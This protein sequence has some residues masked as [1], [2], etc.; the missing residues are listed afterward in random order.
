ME[1]LQ[2]RFTFTTTDNNFYYVPPEEWNPLNISKQN[3]RDG[4]FPIRSVR[5]GRR[6][7]KS[8]Y[9]DRGGRRI[10]VWHDEECHWDVQIGEGA[11]HI[12]VSHTGKNLSV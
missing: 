3:W 10:W 8:G 2:K 4:S 9:R 11:D 6:A 1:R 5:L 7:G 12:N